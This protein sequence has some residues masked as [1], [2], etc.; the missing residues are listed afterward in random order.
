M[1]SYRLPRP[2]RAQISR[3]R[4]H[5]VLGLGVCCILIFGEGVSRAA[6]FHSRSEIARLAFPNGDR[7]ETRDIFLSRNQRSEIE[8]NAGS[9]LAGDLLTIYEGY[10]D[11]RL[12]GYALLDTHIVRTLPETLLIVLDASGAVAA[13]YLMAFHE[14][15][16]YRANDRWLGIFDDRRLS[17]DL[18]VGRS[19]VGITGSTLTARAIVGSI[20]RSLAIYE[21]LLADRNAIRRHRRMD[22]KSLTKSDRVLLS[23]L[24]CDP[25]DHEHRTVLLQDVSLPVVRR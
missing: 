21:I 18:R 11:G 15:L 20:R 9:Q 23:R 19:I 12:V 6:V 7:V 17:D 10:T 1:T 16:D 14:P 4:R 3:F 25:V 13:T 2:G 24:Y 5:A 22:P 8:R